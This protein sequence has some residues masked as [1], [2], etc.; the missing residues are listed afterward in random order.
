[1]AGKKVL[2]SSLLEVFSLLSLT[3]LNLEMMTAVWFGVYC[4]R[5]LCVLCYVMGLHQD[6]SVADIADGSMQPDQQLV[7]DSL[8]LLFF[9]SLS[10]VSV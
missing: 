2:L 6:Q 1:L 10:V 9:L 3:L 8:V 7:P 4:V 5:K